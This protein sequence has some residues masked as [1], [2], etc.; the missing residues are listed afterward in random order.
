MT[1]TSKDLFLAILAL[2]SYN[3][4][5]N[6]GLSGLLDA[7]GTQIGTARIVKT[8]ED[9][10]G[11]AKSASFYAVAYDVSNVPGFAVGDKVISYRGT[12]FDANIWQDILF[13]WSLSLGFG[14]ASEAQLAKKF[15]TD[16]THLPLYATNAQNVI[17]TGHSLG[18][19][20][21]DTIIVY[22]GNA[23][24]TNWHLIDG[25]AGNDV[26]DSRCGAWRMAA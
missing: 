7:A 17:L 12:E 11:I 16:V 3:R 6:P 23:Q 1:T 2:D 13:G 25:G 14:D 21:N 19:G 9:P 4:G 24:Q 18:G 10:G 15:Y 20:G 5:Y 26:I 8:A 22:H